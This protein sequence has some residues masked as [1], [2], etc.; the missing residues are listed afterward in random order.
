MAV[1]AGKGLDNLKQ[2]QASWQDATMR[3]GMTLSLSLCGAE[4]GTLLLASGTDPSS[5]A[6]MHQISYLS[7]S[8]YVVSNHVFGH[9]KCF[10]GLE[11]HW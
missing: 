1:P 9:K 2:R 7:F 3:D 6:G 4:S 10:L 8:H 11:Y 5:R